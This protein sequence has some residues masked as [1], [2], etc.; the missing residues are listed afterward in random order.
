ML[1]FTRR[2]SEVMWFSIAQS[3][4][5]MKNESGTRRGLTER[6][7]SASRTSSRERI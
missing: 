5:R 1:F 6:L 7:L 3:L 2:R 4:R